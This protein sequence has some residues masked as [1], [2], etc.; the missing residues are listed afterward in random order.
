MSNDTERMAYRFSV[1]RDYAKYRLET[2]LRGSKPMLDAKQAL[3]DG[4]AAAGRV[5]VSEIETRIESGSRDFFRDG[6]E[7]AEEYQESRSMQGALLVLAGHRPVMEW[8]ETGV[9]E[10]RVTLVA[11]TVRA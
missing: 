6:F 8:A 5:L 11:E 3:R 4:I 1:T 10:W 2:E 9:D 7:P